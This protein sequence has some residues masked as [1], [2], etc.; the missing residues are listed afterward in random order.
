MIIA[1]KILNS[2][3]GNIKL[4]A[5]INLKK[6]VEKVDSQTCVFEFLRSNSSEMCMPKESER[7]SATAIIII[8]P[9]I[10]NLEL[11]LEYNPIISPRVVIMPDVS[12][13]PNPFF[14][15]FLIISKASNDCFPLN[16]ILSDKCC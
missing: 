15:D 12:P 10:A 5:K 7:E 3:N 8:P 2:K 6:N 1:V 16:L 13:K 4:I 14:I 9:I 11:V